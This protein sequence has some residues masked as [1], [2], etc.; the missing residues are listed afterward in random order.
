MRYW[1]SDKIRQ[2]G[3]LF[4]ELTQEQEFSSYTMREFSVT[5]TKVR[6]H[7]IVM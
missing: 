7:V 2:H 5:N 6:S 4:I 3:D 1:P